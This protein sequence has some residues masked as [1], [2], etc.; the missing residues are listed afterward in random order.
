MEKIY[1]DQEQQQR[2]QKRNKKFNS[3]NVSLGLS[4]AVAFVAIV[5]ILFV[6][7]SGTSYA[8]DPEATLPESLYTKTVSE[9]SDQ[10][11]ATGVQTVDVYHASSSATATDDYL[12]YCLE[13]G[14]DYEANTSLNRDEEIEDYGLI[15]LTSKLNAITVNTSDFGGISEDDAAKIK[16]WVSQVAIWSYLGKAYPNEKTATGK[17]INSTGFIDGS[18]YTAA[19][20]VKQLTFRPSGS[21]PTNASDTPFFTKYGV[22]DMI[23]KALNYHNKGI[24]PLVLKINKASGNFT[25]Y[26]NDKYF[27]SPKL[28]ISYTPA[29]EGLAS[30]QD[31]YELSLDGA[32]EGSYIEGINIATKK[33][34]KLSETDLSKLKLSEYKEFYVVVPKDKVTEKTK[35]FTVNTYGNFD[36]LTGYYYRPGQG[37]EAQTIT[38]LKKIIV[39]R[40]DYTTLKITYAPDVPNTAVSVSQSIYLIGLI[41]LLSGLGI[42]YV[43]VKKQQKQN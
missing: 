28:T 2:K 26:E 20:S 23:T 16:Y 24:N 17:L 7:L 39:S 27:R 41:V 22:T 34:V 33:A 19:Q 43:N 12:V 3:L 32:P 29:E 30:V 15:Y 8:A 10:L 4:F 11:I 6:S 18:M 35:S 40:N 5:S 38:T 13:S 37:V 31:N 1:V 42:L 9:L 36:V 25:L 21:I 14:V